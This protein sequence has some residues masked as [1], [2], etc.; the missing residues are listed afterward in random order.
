MS[1]VYHFYGKAAIGGDQEK[2]VLKT[3]KKSWK[4]SAKSHKSKLKA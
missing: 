1:N 2:G 3:L 4:T